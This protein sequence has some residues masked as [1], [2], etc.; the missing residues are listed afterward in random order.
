MVIDKKITMIQAGAGDCPCFGK[1]DPMFRVR[2]SWDD[3]KSQSGA[4]SV[5]ENAVAYADHFQQTVFDDAGRPLYTGIPTMFYMAKLLKAVKGYKKGQTVQVLR[6]QDK[7]WLIFPEL[8]E[9]SKSA[10]DLTKQCYDAGR[11]FTKAEAEGWVNGKG[12]KSA[13]EY[14]FWAS[15]YTQRA[16]IFQGKKGAWRLIK[17]MPCGTGSIKDSDASDPGIYLGTST[18]IWNKGDTTEKYKESPNS[19]WKGPRAYQRWNMHYSS[20]WGNSIHAGGTGKPSTH[21][22]IALGS[23]QAEWAYKTLPIKTRVVQY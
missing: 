5:Y 21:G 12:F 19:T 6:G 9:V 2:K 3:A 13:T 1:E 23:K 8:I 16:Y 14:L 11:K 17:T 4:F 22:C 20:A 18:K 7:R 15:K 10:I